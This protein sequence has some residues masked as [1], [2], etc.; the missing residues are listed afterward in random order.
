MKE[1]GFR[2]RMVSIDLSGPETESIKIPLPNK[3]VLA[4][5]TKEKL[6]VIVGGTS[7]SASAASASTLSCPACTAESVGSRCSGGR[8][9]P[10]QKNLSW[11]NN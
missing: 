1:N 9:T 2:F 8:K 5:L 10:E 4:N 3:A 11:V 6:A 7:V